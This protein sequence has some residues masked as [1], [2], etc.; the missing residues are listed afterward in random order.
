MS[1]KPLEI[2][3]TI[4]INALK[5]SRRIRVAASPYMHVSPFR[6]AVSVPV[7]EVMEAL[8]INEIF[9]HSRFDFLFR[10]EKNS[11]LVF[12]VPRLRPAG[13]KLNGKEAMTDGW[14]RAAKQEPDTH[15]IY[16]YS[17]T[18]RMTLFPILTHPVKLPISVLHE[19]GCLVA[20]IKDAKD[21]WKH[22]TPRKKSK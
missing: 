5:N 6:N 16:V 12:L 22:A 15:R 19:H 9:S 4:A 17:R 1:L 7:S 11:G 21:R 20:S 3:K 10:Y 13:A 14:F 8:N 2:D 18:L